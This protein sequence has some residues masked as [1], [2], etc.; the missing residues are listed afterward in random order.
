MAVIEGAGLGTPI[1]SAGAPVG[2][3]DEVQ[4]I[5]IGGTPEAGS[6]FRLAF[7]GWTSAPIAWSNVNATLVAA[8]DAALEALANIGVGEVVTAVGTMTAGV[9][10]ATVTFSGANVAKRNVGQLV[11]SAFL[12]SNGTA[13]AGTVAVATT[14]PGVGATGSGISEGGAA[15]RH[16]ERDP[17]PEHRDGGSADLDDAVDVRPSAGPSWGRD[18]G[19]G[20]AAPLAPPP[21]EADGSGGWPVPHGQPPVLRAAAIARKESTGWERSPSRN[22]STWTQ[23]ARRPRM[24]PRRRPSGRPPGPRSPRRMRRPRA[25]RPRRSQGDEGRRGSRGRQVADVPHHP[26]GLPRAQRRDLPGR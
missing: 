15:D 5:T 10:T 9:G 14:T 6:T 4:T 21:V 16:H 3:T 2:G 19:S 11:G 7:E 23:T 18:G 1:Q 13:S 25:T 26:G 8:I 22:G 20:L 17:L 12:Q 24:R